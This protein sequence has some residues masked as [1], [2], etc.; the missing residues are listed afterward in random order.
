MT[1][2]FA[3][4]YE[5][6]ETIPDEQAA[7]DHFRAIRWKRGE[8]C[9]FCGHGTIYHFSDNRTH[10]CQSCRRRFSIRVGT[11][12]EDTKIPLRK[13]LAA[14]WLITSHKKGIASTQLARDLHITQ[15]SAWFVLHRLRHAARTRSFNRPLKGEVEADETFFGGK[16][17]NKHAHKRGKD[18]KVVVFGV[19]ERGGELRARPLKSLKEAKLEI[20]RHVEPGTN[21]MTD[22][23]PGYRGL[24]KRFRHHTVNHSAG[25]YVK[26]YFA[27]VNGIE[28]VWSLLKRQVY[29]IHHWVSRKHLHRYIDEAVW[30]FNR[31]KVVDG[32]RVSEF[33]SRADGRLKYRVLIAKA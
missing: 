14:V 9:P 13:W 12:F 28:G 7:I 17:K 23:W 2:E 30:R 19:L 1:H 10:K 8:F 31:R 32:H 15:K 20:V 3:S 18:D 29:G 5:L 27:H 4:L 21:V 22:E 16:D 25:Q 11:I 6:F 24:G 33:L 26:H